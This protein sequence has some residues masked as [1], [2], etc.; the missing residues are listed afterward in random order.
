M[1]RVMRALEPELAGSRIKPIDLMSGFLMRTSARN[2]LRGTI[3]SLQS[4]RINAEVGVRVSEQT[5]H[6]C[7]RHDGERARTRAVRR[8]RGDRAHQGVLRGGGA[9]RCGEDL[10]AATPS[11]ATCCAARSRRS[12]RRSCIDIG[13]G[14]TLAAS[15]SAQSAKALDIAAG[16][17]ACL[18]AVRSGACHHRHRLREKPDDRRLRLDPGVRGAT[19]LGTGLCGRDQCRRRGE[20]HRC[21]EGDRRRLQ[22]EDR[23]RGGPE[24]RLLRPASTRRSRRSAPFKVF[25]SADDERPKKAVDEGFGVAV[26]PL[27]LCDRQDRAVERRS[28]RRK[29]RGD[30]ERQ[31]VSTKSRS[32]IRPPRP[33]APP[34]SRR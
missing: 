23:P 3:V 12:T 15:I 24:L 31:R 18:R 16:V 25:L 14:K 27:H 10:G 22:G 7:A 11:P 26:E 29:G 34:P 20:F 28:G 5:H 1:A 2:A 32:P 17:Q 30:A 9:R 19:C 21:G 4:E 6:L 13:D 33:M 8:P